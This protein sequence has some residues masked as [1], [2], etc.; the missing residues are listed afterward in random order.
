MIEMTENGIWPKNNVLITGDRM[1]T[2]ITERTSSK[3]FNTH[4]RSFPGAHVSDM[5]DYP[6]PLLRKTP[7]KIILVKWANGVERNSAQ[8]IMSEIKA[9]RQFIH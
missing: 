6:K 9:L 1:L 7:G 8:T 3:N 4:V 5:F 2:D